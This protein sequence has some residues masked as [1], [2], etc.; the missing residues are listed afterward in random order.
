MSL[1]ADVSTPAGRPRKPPPSPALLIG[2]AVVLAITLWAG[3]S[4]EFTLAPLFTDLTR[5]K[6]IIDQ[7]L[8]P[9]WDFLLRPAVAAAFLETLYIAILASLGGCILAL[10]LAMLASKVS[11]PNTLVYRITRGVL[12]LVRS[13]PDV[14]YGLLFVAVLGTGALPGVLALIMFNIGVAAKLTGETID[15]I[16]P[17]P[18]EAVEAAGGNRLQRARWAIF[19]QVAPNYLSYCFYVFELN[20]RASLVLGIVGAGGIGTLL[21][22]LLARFEYS[23]VSAIVVLL[24]VVVFILD[25]LS[26]ALRRRLS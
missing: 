7:F 13:L 22:T 21:Y 17:G 3:L 19:P 26:R 15:S 23:Q 2:L 6:V 18:V 20:I 25:Q 8:R 11:A 9:E 1:V 12:S 24:F 10:L 16:D 4:I 5:G 14:A